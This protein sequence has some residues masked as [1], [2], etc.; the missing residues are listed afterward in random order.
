MCSPTKPLF[1]YPIL[2]RCEWTCPHGMCSNISYTTLLC[3]SRREGSS[4]S[5]FV[6]QRFHQHQRDLDPV[7]LQGVLVQAAS[8]LGHLP[9]G[10]VWVIGAK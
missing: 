2:V 1:P 9:F 5:P 8:L 4:E 3:A 7:D 6:A 10:E